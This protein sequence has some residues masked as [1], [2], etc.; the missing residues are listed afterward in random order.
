MPQYIA[1]PPVAASNAGSRHGPVVQ[2]NCPDLPL[3]QYSDRPLPDT[4]R[5]SQYSQVSSRVDQ[6]RCDS[7]PTQLLQGSING[8]TL[9][10]PSEVEL[11]FGGRPHPTCQAGHL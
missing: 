2:R 5:K 11:D 3:S 9:S 8:H 4:W 1:L 7:V 10:D 6:G